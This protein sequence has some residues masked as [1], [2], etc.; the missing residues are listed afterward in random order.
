[1]GLLLLL[2]TSTVSSEECGGHLTARR[3]VISTPN[4]PGQFVVPIHCRWVLDASELA[5]HQ[6]NSS[7]VVYLSQLYA[8]RGLRFTEYAYYGSEAASFGAAVIHEIDEGNVF[9]LRLLRT[10]RPYLVLEFELDRL[11]GNHVRV[12]DKL[13]DVYGFNLTYQIG[14]ESADESESCSLKDCSFAGDCLLAADYA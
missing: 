13:L 1:M 7:I 2:S 12:L 14:I 5:E 11:E 10:F 8:F 9:E 4:F 6:T 3:G